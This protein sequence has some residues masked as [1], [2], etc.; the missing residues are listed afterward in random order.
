MIDSSLGFRS[1]AF[2]YRL[3]ISRPLLPD[4]VNELTLKQLGVGDAAVEGTF[5]RNSLGEVAV[6]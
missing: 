2:S 6:E 4:S 1:D 5:K 3:H